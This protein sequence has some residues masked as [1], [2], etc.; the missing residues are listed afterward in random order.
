MTDNQ[1]TKKKASNDQS[2]ASAVMSN[3]EEGNIR[4]AIRIITS[5]DAAQLSTTFQFTVEDVIAAIRSF[6]A[7]SAGGPEVVRPL[8]LRD[9]TSNKETWPALISALTA[10]INLLMQDK[11]G[12]SSV[13]QILFGGRLI[14]EEIGR[15]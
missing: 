1:S 15:H 4:A 6:P 12:S 9:L 7:G 13:S 8:H 2:L 10:F 3:I 14:A 5:G 11:C